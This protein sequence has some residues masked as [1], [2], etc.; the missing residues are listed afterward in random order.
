ML[1]KILAT[2]ISSFKNLRSMMKIEAF[3]LELDLESIR[4]EF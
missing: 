4:L 2:S 1:E 3:K